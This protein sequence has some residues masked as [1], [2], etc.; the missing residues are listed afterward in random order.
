MVPAW[1]RTLIF[2]YSALGPVTGGLLF[3][4]LIQA[5]NFVS[6][7]SL[8]RVGALETLRGVGAGFLK[9]LPVSYVVGLVPAFLTGVALCAVLLRFPPLR[10]RRLA[11]SGVALLIGGASSTVVWPQSPTE[12]AP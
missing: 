3:L 2:A 9:I 7:P 6:R 5:D 10:S 1:C 11:R 12:G 4:L 8:E